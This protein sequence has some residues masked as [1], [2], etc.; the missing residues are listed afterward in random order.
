[1]VKPANHVASKVE[2]RGRADAF[3]LSNIQIRL[4][5]MTL[6]LSPIMLVGSSDGRRR[7]C[8]ASLSHPGLSPSQ[9][10]SRIK[11]CMTKHCCKHECDSSLNVAGA[12]RT[13]HR[14]SPVTDAH[15]VRVTLFS[16]PYVQLMPLN[17]VLSASYCKSLQW[18]K[19][20]EAD[21]VKLQSTCWRPVCS[22]EYDMPATPR[23]G[24]V[25]GLKEVPSNCVQNYVKALLA[26]TGESRLQLLGVTAGISDNDLLRSQS[27]EAFQYCLDLHVL[28][29]SANMSA[30]H[31][32]AS[33]ATAAGC[34][35]C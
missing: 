4:N 9:H 30:S 29:F 12:R 14:L 22:S 34:T 16:C 32:D 25:A 21:D 15:G 8:Q 17:I 31:R 11:Q 18:Y 24:L 3:T 13:S 2:L 5:A 23:H 28:L 20:V 6:L 33:M 1:M 19:S 35:Y 27:W 7:Y 26:D 10:M